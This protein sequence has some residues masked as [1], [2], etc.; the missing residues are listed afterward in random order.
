MK[1]DQADSPLAAMTPIP[2]H[3]RHLNDLATRVGLAVR[4]YVEPYSDDPEVRL[5]SKW[6]GTRAQLFATGLFTST[7][8]RR[9]HG[10]SKP[11]QVVVPP[12]ESFRRSNYIALGVLSEFGES[13]QWAIDCGPSIYTLSHSGTAELVTYADEILYHGDAEALIAAG[14]DRK[15]LPLGKQGFKSTRRSSCDTVEAQ[16]NCRRQPDGLLIY[17]QETYQALQARHARHFPATAAPSQPRERPSHLRLV[18]DNS[19]SVQ[20]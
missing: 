13:V 5:W 14:V 19:R 6:T 10:G 18:V 3:I 1:A 12:S 7:E 2:R 20:S 17:R 4:V 15:R 16:W 9:I 8:Q 11:R